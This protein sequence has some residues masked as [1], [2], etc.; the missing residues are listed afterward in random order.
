MQVF[1]KFIYFFYVFCVCFL[2][3]TIFYNIYFKNAN[4]SKKKKDGNYFPSF[5]YSSIIKVAP[6]SIFVKRKIP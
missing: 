3:V 4:T 1:M 6:F 2:F 5:E